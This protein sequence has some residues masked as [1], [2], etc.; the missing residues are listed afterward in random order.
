MG[1]QGNLVRSSR[2]TFG[3]TSMLWLVVFD[4][5][6]SWANLGNNLPRAM[7]HHHKS[8]QRLQLLGGCTLDLLPE[9]SSTL[10][11]SHSFSFS[12]NIFENCASRIPSHQMSSD[13]SAHCSKIRVPDHSVSLLLL[14]LRP[15]QNRTHIF[16]QNFVLS[17][18]NLTPLRPKM[19]PFTIEKSNTMSFWNCFAVSY[20]C[21]PHVYFP[22]I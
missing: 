15:K 18:Q 3:I 8:P 13:T 19:M 22:S 20:S 2:L 21:I 12:E 14:F 4:K 16:F 11:F 5:Y 6:S 9:I 10:L 17:E 7:F 1:Q